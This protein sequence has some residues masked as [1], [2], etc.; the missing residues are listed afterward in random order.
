MQSSY[1]CSDKKPNSKKKLVRLSRGTN[2]QKNLFLVHDGT[3]RIEG[4]FKFAGLVSKEFSV[5]GITLHE[6]VGCIPQN[7]T[8][9]AIAADYIQAIKGIQPEGSYYIAGWSTGGTIA[10]EMANQLEK[11]GT[12][13]S[14]CALIDSASPEYYA[15]DYCKE[16]SPA[17]EME[18]V[19]RFI[20]D[21]VLRERLI[22]VESVSHF[23][24][25]INN[26]LRQEDFEKELFFQSAASNWIERIP[27]YQSI[28][29]DVLFCSINIMRTLHTATSS[30]I[31]DNKI[32]NRVHLF[33]AVDSP[34]K[35]YNSWGKYS[36]EVMMI[37]I[38]GDHYSIFSEGNIQHFMDCFNELLD[39]V[40]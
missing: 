29:L 32:K 20:G 10:F 17:S 24:N 22:G 7:I 11:T 40:Y 27:N 39:T 26:E 31:P 9:E 34:V 30:Y 23:W 13:V 38:S 4:Y 33:Q 8:I 3:G 25:E 21:E 28:P 18:F 15:Q 5:Y 14:L 2:P 35:N 1:S 12:D 6:K 36:Q 16:L 37:D 19:G